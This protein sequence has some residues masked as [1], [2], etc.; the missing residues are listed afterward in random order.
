MS[1]SLNAHDPIIY[2]KAFS[3]SKKVLCIFDGINIPK[4]IYENL[5]RAEK[6]N[7]AKFGFNKHEIEL[8]KL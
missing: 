5:K 3:G 7:V 1:F 4:E 2:C 8:P 6:I